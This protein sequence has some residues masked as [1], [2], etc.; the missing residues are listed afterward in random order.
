MTSNWAITDAVAIFVLPAWQ[1]KQPFV[2]PAGSINFSS[3]KPISLTRGLKKK[4]LLKKTEFF[5]HLLI[6][7]DATPQCMRGA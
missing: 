3:T 7:L 6:F 4:T 2:I 5:S 1:A